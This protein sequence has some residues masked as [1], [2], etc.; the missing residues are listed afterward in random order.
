MKKNSI[1]VMVD[2]E[3]TGISAGCCILSIG[4][5]TFDESSS[6]YRK[7]SHIDC[8]ERG[9][10]DSMDTINWWSKQ[11]A[12]AR[13]EAFSGV[14]PLID[15]LGNLAEFFLSLE[16]EYMNVYVWGNGAD[17]DLPILGAAY[18]ITGMKKPW[19]PFNGRCYRTLKNLYQEV[20]ADPFTG[21]KHSAIDD[22]VFQA[23][24]AMKILRS[25]KEQKFQD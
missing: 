17:F 1:D 2:L 16:R 11:S 3:T 9:L 7:I 24:H 14:A 10:K 6:F 12:E 8:L 5:V 20:K 23:R 4:A 18:E 15:I 22:A 25:R 21:L 19:K 13:M